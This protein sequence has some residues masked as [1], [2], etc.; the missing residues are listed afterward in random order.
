LVI[1]MQIMSD[2]RWIGREPLRLANSLVDP[3]YLSLQ[4]NKIT[5]PYL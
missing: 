5:L 4:R 1:P 3:Y 2:A